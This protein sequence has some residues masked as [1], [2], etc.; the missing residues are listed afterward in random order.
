MIVT[1]PIDI[2]AML[3]QAHRPE[4]GGIVLFSGE[5]RNSHKG[6]AVAYLE[7]EAYAPMAAGMISAIVAEAIDTWGLEYAAAVHRVGKMEISESA[8]VVVTAHAHRRQAYEANQFIIDAIKR[9]VPIWKCEHFADGSHEWGANAEAM[10]QAETPEMRQ[11][12][13]PGTHNEAAQ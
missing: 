2:T 12:K 1:T 3:Q 6:R 8:V 7:Y 13:M 5:V 10:K 11:E 9:D 4:A